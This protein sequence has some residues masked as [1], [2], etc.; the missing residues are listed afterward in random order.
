M[1]LLTIPNEPITTLNNLS[2]NSPAIARNSSSELVT[3]TNTEQ[4][5]NISQINNSSSVAVVEMDDNFYRDLSFLEDNFVIEN[6]IDL[7]KDLKYRIILKT[8]TK[9]IFLYRYT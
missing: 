2:R 7:N 4:T 3:T 6:N 1:P 9:S 8:K 5:V